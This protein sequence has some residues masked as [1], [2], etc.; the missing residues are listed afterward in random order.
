MKRASVVLVLVVGCGGG[1]G[2]TADAPVAD[3]R[4]DASPP[5]ASP[6]ARVDAAPPGPGE[7]VMDSVQVPTTSAEAQSLGT[8]L[9][10]DL[11]GGDAAVDNQF[12]SVLAA[13]STM[14]FDVSGAVTTGIDR[15]TTITLLYFDPT[16]NLASFV[17]ANPNPPACTG[18]T[19]T[20]CR[21]HL[22][23]HAGF[24]LAAGAPTGTM[25]TTTVGTMTTGGP[26]TAVVQLAPF[27]DPPIT[28]ALIGARFHGTIDATGITGKL[29][30][31]IPAAEIDSAIIPGIGNNVRAAI[32]HDCPTAVPPSCMCDSGSTGENLI[33]IFDFDGDCVVTDD[34]LRTN[35]LIQ[36]F[37][38]P[39]VTIDG[40]DGL[41]F[42]FGVTAVR[43]SFT[44]P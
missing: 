27:G 7:Y 6:D 42:G 3:A 36:G 23:G 37:L 22:D 40:V 30:G 21:H 29:G 33:N 35:P 39:D 17:G 32:L 31:E 2:T 11:P 19:D 5:D 41:S 9:D 28:V 44:P 8:D 18:P 12:G 13:L 26:G 43:A 15:G 4:A 1:D 38:M 20:V 25:P 24:D 16:A 14:N 10:G 34:E